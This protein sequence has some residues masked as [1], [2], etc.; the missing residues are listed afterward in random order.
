MNKSSDLAINLMNLYNS[1][2]YVEFDKGYFI[3][4]PQMSGYFYIFKDLVD[5]KFCLILNTS[6]IK[7]NTNFTKV[8]EYVYIVFNIPSLDEFIENLSDEYMSQLLEIISQQMNKE[9]T[10]NL[11]YGYYYDENGELKI[12]IR[13]AREVREIYDRYIDVESIRQIADERKEN[14]SFIRDVLHDNEL[15]MQMQQK[16]LPATI[17]K[18]VNNLLAQNV[19]GRFRKETFEDKLKAIRDRKKKLEQVSL[20]ANVKQ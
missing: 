4:Q 18:N 6:D 7:Y 17:L 12:D 13:K 9:D 2:S 19:K 8:E 14:F 16:I 5:P 20:Q 11:P 10:R 1:N 15:Y 3:N